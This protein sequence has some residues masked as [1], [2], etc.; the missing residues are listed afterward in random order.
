MYGNSFSYEVKL[1]A[2]AGL[3]GT[4]HPVEVTG[5]GQE[6]GNSIHHDYPITTMNVLYGL[7]RMR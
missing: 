1:Y 5:Y 6:F 2:A 4:Y 7:S 3:C